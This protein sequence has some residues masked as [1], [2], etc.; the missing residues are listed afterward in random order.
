[1]TDT[2]KQIGQQTS[3][4]LCSD[5]FESYILFIQKLVP[6]FVLDQ[7][8]DRLKLDGEK[9]WKKKKKEKAFKSQVFQ[10]VASFET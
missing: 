3:L 1:M 2:I 5:F 6:H 7:G 9:M 10:S 4:T 8:C